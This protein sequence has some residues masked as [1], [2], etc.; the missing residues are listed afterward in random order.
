M[1][2]RHIAFLQVFAPLG[3]IEKFIDKKKLLVYTYIAWNKKFTKT[4]FY[5]I[6]V[7]WFHKK[8]QFSFNVWVIVRIQ[9]QETLNRF[10][11]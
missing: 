3:E 5:P 11:F 6:V 7:E 1:T 9:S 10:S 2:V 4:M 8:V